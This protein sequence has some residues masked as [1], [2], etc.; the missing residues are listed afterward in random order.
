[1]IFLL[2]AKTLLV[3]TSSK[4]THARTHA[5]AHAHTHTHTHKLDKN[6]DWLVGQTSNC[7]STTKQ[8]I[9]VL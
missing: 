7:L 9:N 6:R 4:N 5:H 3:T 1:M 2:L 8:M